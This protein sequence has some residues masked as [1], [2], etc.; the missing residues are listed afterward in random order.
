METF[1]PVPP[2]RPAACLTTTKGLG[3]NCTYEQYPSAEAWFQA[4][5][6]V[7]KFT[8]SL[9]DLL[10]KHQAVLKANDLCARLIFEALLLT[11]MITNMGDVGHPYLEFMVRGGGKDTMDFSSLDILVAEIHD[12]YTDRVFLKVRI[13]RDPESDQLLITSVTT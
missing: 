2:M 5:I 9:T 8:Q 4:R 11:A 12:A 6:G 10:N 7:D 1:I 3:F 13:T